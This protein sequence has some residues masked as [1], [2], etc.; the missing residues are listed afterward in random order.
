MQILITNDDGIDSAGL[1]AMARAASR[2]G[3][4]ILVVAPDHPSSGASA[5]IGM[6]LQHGQPIFQQEHPL[7]M[8]DGVRCLVAEA[9]PAQIVYLAA[10]GEFGKPPAMVL[11]GINC[12]V[13]TG[14]AIIHSGTV[15]VALTASILGIRTMAVSVAGTDP[16]HWGTAEDVTVRVM[17]WV[18]FQPSDGRILNVNIPDLPMDRVR[19]FRAAPLA[20]FGSVQAADVDFP[21]DPVSDVRRVAV[22]YEPG[23][24]RLEPGT[25]H[26]LVERGWATATMLRGLT[27]DFSGVT[28]PSY[29][30]ISPLYSRRHSVSQPWSD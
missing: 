23:F 19:G 17:E 13:N 24:A 16:E 20:V 7:G 8:P 25:D 6:R 1:A 5:S 4:E 11:S 3:H 2:R 28:L 22:Q 9:T 30:Q 12:G 21:E 29:D 14:R 18:E 15:G 27:D 26:Y 10:Q